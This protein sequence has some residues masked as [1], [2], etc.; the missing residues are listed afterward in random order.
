M[1]YVNLSKTLQKDLTQLL[2][3]HCCNNVCIVPQNKTHTSKM[4]FGE[5][6]IFSSFVIWEALNMPSYYSCNNLLFWHQNDTHRFWQGWQKGTP[7]RK[8]PHKAA[9]S[10]LALCGSWMRLSLGSTSS[11]PG[12]RQRGSWHSY[13]GNDIPENCKSPRSQFQNTQKS[14]K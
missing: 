4:T 10:G 13:L 6:I 12:M 14:L 9:G 8:S 11:L 2:K 5:H 1:R 3:W 7:C